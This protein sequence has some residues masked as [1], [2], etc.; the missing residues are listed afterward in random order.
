MMDKEKVLSKVT[1]LLALARSQGAAPNEVETALRQARHLMK[2]YNLDHIEVAAHSIQETSIATKTRRAPQ[3]WLHSLAWICAEAFDCSHLAY[4][5]PLLGWSFKFLGKGIASELAAHTYSTLHH[6]LVAARRAHVAQQKRCLPK[7]KR[8]RGKL[9]AEGW[10]S[11]V[12]SKVTQ[13]AGGVDKTTELEI[14]AYLDWHHPAMKLVTIKPAEAKGHDTRSLHA[15]WEQGQHA[16][17]H[18]GVAQGPQRALGIG[19]GK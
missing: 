10:L 1:K 12:T 11:A 7:M 13:F 15:G 14:Q 4:F 9:F 3:D 8:H 17:L 18:R 6:Q 19:G 5:N 2:Q 16:K